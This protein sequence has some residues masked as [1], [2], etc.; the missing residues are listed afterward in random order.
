MEL[1]SDRRRRALSGELGA[2]V[3]RLELSRI[4]ES[5]PSDELLSRRQKSTVV[6]VSVILAVTIVAAATM[7]YFVKRI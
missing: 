7:R 6:I 1:D 3:Q 2:D 4:A 5:A